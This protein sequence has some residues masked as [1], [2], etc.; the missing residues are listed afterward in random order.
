MTNEITL[1]VSGRRVRFLFAMKTF[2]DFQTSRNTDL[3]GLFEYCRADYLGWWR[4]LV[5]WAAINGGSE[6]PDPFTPDVVF[7]WFDDM[8]ES[9]HDKLKS[10]YLN[11][12]IMGKRIGG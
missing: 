11:T 4:D 10:T 1:K 7:T 8:S 9:D 2:Y 5:Y 6:L 12:R 3:S